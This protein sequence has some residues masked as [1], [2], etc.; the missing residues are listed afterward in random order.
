MTVVGVGVGVGVAA[1]DDCRTHIFRKE[2]NKKIKKPTFGKK[3]RS[4]SF[5]N[6]NEILY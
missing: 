6:V 1:A 3:K 4:K 2:R 5:P